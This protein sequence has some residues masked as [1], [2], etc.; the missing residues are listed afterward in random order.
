MPLL[1]GE[2]VELT[3]E[4]L[5][6]SDRNLAVELTSFIWRVAPD[7]ARANAE[8]AIR[9]DR[10]SAEGWLFHAPREQL[11]HLAGLV[12]ARRSLPGWAPGWAYRRALDG[13]P[14]AEQLY[15]IA[16]GGSPRWCAVAAVGWLRR[17]QSPWPEIGV[18]CNEAASTA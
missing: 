10:T 9:D 2:D 14:A 13:G 5:G 12:A 1:D 8:A 3:L 16:L 15:R 17:W 7:R 11:L 4:L 18:T 6:V